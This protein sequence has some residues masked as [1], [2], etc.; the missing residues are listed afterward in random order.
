MVNNDYTRSQ[1]GHV[2]WNNE[3]AKL[4]KN[5]FKKLS[6]VFPLADPITNILLKAGQFKIAKIQQKTKN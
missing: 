6:N 5:F 1:D 4:K 3:A 2:G